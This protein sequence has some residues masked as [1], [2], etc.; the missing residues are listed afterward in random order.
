MP[1]GAASHG[2][3]AMT[4]VRWLAFAAVAATL[5]AASGLA[6]APARAQVIWTLPSAYPADNFHSENLAAFARDLAQAT[7][8]K[9]AVELHPNASLLPASAI[10]SAVRIG[11]VQMGEVLVSLLDNE[12][13]IFGIDVVPFLAGSYDDARNLWAAS[14]PTVERGLAAQG[15]MVLFAVPW[16]PQGIFANK[17][18]NRIADMKGLSWRVYNSAT[19]RIAQIVGA[20]PVT[21]QAA[22]LRDA[23]ATGLINALMTSGATGYDVR[24]WETMRYFYD[25]QA[26]IPK[27]ITFANKA[28]FDRL[29]KPTQDAVLKGAAAAE[30]RGW[31]W[32]QDKAKWFTDQLAAHGM[33]VL[34]PSQALR[35]ELQQIGDRLTRE[36]L[37]RVGA[38]GQAI[39]EAYRKLQ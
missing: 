2:P 18:I 34:P 32:S 11:Q 15:L 1:A 9:L 39:I 30:A 20:Y 14:K 7:G 27:N 12:D 33:T 37:A 23:L 19:R 24:I 28:A 29:D 25:T 17:E 13:P 8:G 21:I 31:R 4:N 16:P 6:S 36:W 22:D 35:T 26:W 5:A 10:K 38:D 3:Q